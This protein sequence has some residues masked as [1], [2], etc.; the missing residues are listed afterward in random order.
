MYSDLH[1]TLADTKYDWS[2]R[3]LR[4]QGW[5]GDQVDLAAA[6]GGAERVAPAFC[7]IGSLAAA[8]LAS[9]ALAAFLAA[10]AM[11]GAVASNHPAELVAN[12]VAGRRGTAPLPANRAAKRLG[13]VMGVLL[14]GGATVAFAAGHQALGAILAGVMGVTA[15]F[16]AVTNICVPSVIFT[17][18]WG[19]ELAQAPTLTSAIRHRAHTSTAD[20]GPRLSR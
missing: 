13:C 10:S 8:A 16:V 15:A 11:V 20:S 5:R 3:L 7:A 12:A 4:L 19:T 6:S 9:P 18:L 1:Q 14:L 17:L 2:T